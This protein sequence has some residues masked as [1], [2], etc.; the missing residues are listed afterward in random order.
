M[1]KPVTLKTQKETV[2]DLLKRS[3][4]LRDHDA[5]LVVSCIIRKLGSK[6][7]ASMSALDLLIEMEEGRLPHFESI[8]R[9]RQMLQ[10]DHPELRG[11]KYQERNGVMEQEIR[12]EIRNW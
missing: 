10:R 8:R 9:T 12:D 7:V 5:A 11:K 1:R 4:Y 2:E 3:P 6:R